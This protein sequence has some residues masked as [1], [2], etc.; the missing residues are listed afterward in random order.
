MDNTLWNS[1][2]PDIYW[3]MLYPKNKPYARTPY[4][5]STD[6]YVAHDTF[7]LYHYY[8]NDSIGF[9]VYDHDNLSRDDGLGYWHGSMKSLADTSAGK[10][11]FGNVGS[12]N[13]LVQKKG[14]VN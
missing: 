14:I 1:S 7:K 4:E 3:T 5:T 6:Q 10:I 11:A 9:A 12:F 13:V 2:Y 8:P